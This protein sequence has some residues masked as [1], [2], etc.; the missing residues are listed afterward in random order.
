MNPTSD[1]VMMSGGST[2]LLEDSN[3]PE[4]DFHISL[5]SVP[6]CEWFCGSRVSAP[7]EDTD[8]LAVSSDHLNKRARTD[9]EEVSVVSQSSRGQ[10]DLLDAA[11][12]SEVRHGDPLGDSVRQRGE[13]VTYCSSGREADAS[14]NPTVEQLPADCRHILN[15]LA[16][17]SESLLK[18]LRRRLHRLFD[19]VKEIDKLKRFYFDDKVPKSMMPGCVIQLP[20]SS[21]TE[22]ALAQIKSIYSDAAKKA[23]RVTIVARVNVFTEEKAMLCSLLRDFY[24]VCRSQIAEFYGGT[25]VG[26]GRLSWID[27]T[28]TSQQVCLFAANVVRS[29]EI[30][31][32]KFRALVSEHRRQVVT[33]LRIKELARSKSETV[34]M[35]TVVADTAT[36]IASSVLEP[37]RQEIADLR[38]LVERLA[39]ASTPDNAVR[40]S[41]RSKKDRKNVKRANPRPASEVKTGKTAV[42][43]KLSGPSQQSS[44]S[45]EAGN[46]QA[47]K[48]NGSRSSANNTKQL[49]VEAA[50]QGKGEQNRAPAKLQHQRPQQSKS[51]QQSTMTKH[52]TKSASTHSST[53]QERGK[54]SA[55]P[56]HPNQPNKRRNGKQEIKSH[57]H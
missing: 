39:A 14:L 8:V 47:V 41:P 35:E 25:L 21:S 6:T 43:S 26:A 46:G 10:V 45:R 44:V 51:N 56:F 7:S 54:R 50:K 28:A 32:N 16:R 4:L 33:S 29:S 13:D 31:L 17:D 12:S 3:L 18:D 53:P 40:S 9:T 15:E 49:D 24:D 34:P 1:T 5:P 55:T 2:N 27:R 52:V 23:L 42:N 19:N 36:T 57:S 20:A 38:A 37:M 48:S 30:E 11:S 22:S